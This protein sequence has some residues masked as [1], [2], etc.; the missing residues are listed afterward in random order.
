MCQWVVNSAQCS[1]TLSTEYTVGCVS[2]W[3]TIC[4]HGI[5]FILDIIQIIVYII[6]IVRW[7]QHVVDFEVC[8]QNVCWV[9]VDVDVCSWVIREVDVAGVLDAVRTLIQHL[10]TKVPDRAEYRAKVSQVSQLA[11]TWLLF[12]NV[13]SIWLIL[14]TDAGDVLYCPV[15]LWPTLLQLILKYGWRSSNMYTL[16]FSV[17]CRAYNHQ[18]YWLWYHSPEFLYS[19]WSQRSLP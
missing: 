13:R 10:C 15:V 9:S 12:D 2:K 18:L 5:I 1:S 3:S 16:Q 8:I 4:L 19:F 17:N 6:L 11:W 7:L 14:L